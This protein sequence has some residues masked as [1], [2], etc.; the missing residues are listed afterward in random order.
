MTSKQTNH[1]MSGPARFRNSRIPKQAPGRRVADTTNGRWFATCLALLWL[2][3]CTTVGPDFE[4]PQAPVAEKWQEAQ[5]PVYKSGDIDASWWKVFGDAVL[6]ELIEVAYRQNL[7]LQA[8]G[9]RILEARAQL[10]I[11]TGTQYPQQ[12]L[13]AG[14][15][16]YNS[17]SKNA[18]NTSAG[19]LTF[20]DYALSIDA[21]WELDLWGKFR[22][23]IQA[24]DADYLAS[25]AN[26]DDLLVTLTA[27]V[28]NTYAAVRTFEERLTIANENVRLQR[29]SVDIAEARFRGGQVSELDVRQAETLLYRTQAAIPVLT[30]GVQQARN[31]LSILLG[32]LPGRVNE[33][34]GAPGTIPVAP[35]EVAVGI[36]NELLRRRPDVRRAELQAATQSALIGV[37]KADLYPSFSLV[38]S[39]GVLS[40]SGTNSTRSGNSGFD[41]LFSSD[42]LFFVGGP[43]FNWPFLN[44]GRIKNSVRVQDARFQ[45]AVANYQ[46]TVLRAA[47]ETEDAMTGFLRARDETDFRDLAAGA[48]KR[49][50]DLAF[51]QYSEGAADYTKVLLTQQSLAEEQDRLT[52]ARGDV[53]ANLIALYKSLGGGWEVRAGKDVVPNATREEMQKR[54]D[55]GKLLDAQEVD[56]VPDD[57]E[58]REKVSW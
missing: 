56:N 28:A 44:Y 46:N 54:T 24:A 38:G 11:A 8:A 32:M 42:S 55:W 52:T 19:D 10:A 49:S 17:A 16:I 58:Q 31:A 27:D 45:Q 9:L 50:A 34:L 21:A 18:A 3:A 57:P 39:V 36:P 25:I 26:Y 43:Q 40:S 1:S 7:S 5:D 30:A 29:R 4:T 12:Q 33:I 2:T 20:T 53:L 15:A 13:A 22:R 23:G 48:A 37:A 51:V 47:R 6:N 41:S 35:R 14:S